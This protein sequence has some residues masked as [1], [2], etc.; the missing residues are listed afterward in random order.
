[1]IVLSR[2]RSSS[3]SR[4]LMPGDVRVRHEDQEASGHGDLRRQPRA[5]ATHR[6]LRDLDHHRL[7]VLQDLLDPRL[8]SLQVLG[9]VVHLAGVQD[10]VASAPDVDERGFHA[11]EHVLHATQVDVADHR[12][13]AGA[14][15]VV[16]DQ[17]VFLEHRDLVAIAVLR[18]DHD[19]VRDPRHHDGV[20]AAPAPSADASGARTVG[21]QAPGGASGLDLLLGRLDPRPPWRGGVGRGLDRSVAALRARGA[22]RGAGAAPAA[23]LAG[24]RGGR[25]RTVGQGVFPLGVRRGIARRDVIRIDVGDGRV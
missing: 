15:D 11:R 13:S 20:L 1:M 3:G 19:L 10:A 12:T 7:P 6:V 18:D 22:L 23:P 16:L 4:R 8:R 14:R 17:D 5:L 2:R 25:R 24:A 21:T 9:R